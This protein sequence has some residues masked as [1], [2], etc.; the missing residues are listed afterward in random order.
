MAVIF[1]V[2][3]VVAGV[4]SSKRRPWKGGKEEMAVVKA[5]AITSMPLVLAEAATGIASYATGQLSIP[6]ALGFG[7]AIDLGVVMAGLIVALARVSKTEGMEA[8]STNEPENR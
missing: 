8:K 4:W 6:P 7:T 2:I 3:L 1:A 5:F